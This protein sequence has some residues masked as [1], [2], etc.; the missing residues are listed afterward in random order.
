MWK[1]QAVTRLPV[2]KPHVVTAQ[3][4][5]G[6]DDVVLVRLEGEHL[7]AEY[8]DGDSSVTID[9]AYR[10]GTPYDLRI[11]AADG[12]IQIFYDDRLAAEKLCDLLCVV[13]RLRTHGRDVDR[14]G[15]LKRVAAHRA[16]P[17]CPARRWA[18]PRGARSRRP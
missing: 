3:I 16:A 5:G 6:D 18:R 17:G 7:M 1:R 15:R 11:V 4:H 9:P 2:V 8:D 14:T 13:G 10:L 12:R